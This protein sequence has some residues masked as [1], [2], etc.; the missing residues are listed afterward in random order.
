ML[1]AM[2]G[3][4]SCIQLLNERRTSADTLDNNSHTPL[5]WAG[6]STSLGCVKYLL[7][8]C[9]VAVDPVD[10][11][12][13]PLTIA[14]GRGRQFTVE[15]LIKAGADMN[16]RSNGVDMHTPLSFACTC[17]K[18]AKTAAVLV[19]LLLASWAGGAV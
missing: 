6:R 19:N 15:F 2:C 11:K 8:V 13:P 4:Q 7:E 18:G 1:A 14:C 10:H 5:Y 17:D 9:Q 12:D 3:N 16:A